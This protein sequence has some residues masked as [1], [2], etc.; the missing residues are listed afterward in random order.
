MWV[1][2]VFGSWFSYRFVDQLAAELAEEFHRVASRPRIGNAQR[3][4]GHPNPTALAISGMAEA[5][6]KLQSKYKLGFLRRARLAQQVQNRLIAYGYPV[7][8]SREIAYAL[9]TASK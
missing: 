1:R 4:A 6:R 8:V 7:E 5:V 9:S 2:V 3:K